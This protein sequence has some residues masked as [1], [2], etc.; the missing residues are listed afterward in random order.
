MVCLCQGRGIAE[1][2]GGA[3]ECGGVAQASQGARQIGR[4]PTP[5]RPDSATPTTFTL[6]AYS[7]WLPTRYL[8]GALD[9]GL[10]LGL[11]VQRQRLIQLVCHLLEEGVV[12]LRGGRLVGYDE[13]GG[14]TAAARSRDAIRS[15][16][17]NPRV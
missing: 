14:H 16:T 12:L 13:G 2:R 6:A 1:A 3:N 11:Q 9:T 17:V 8:L 7:R 4:H 5:Q 10:A 15:H